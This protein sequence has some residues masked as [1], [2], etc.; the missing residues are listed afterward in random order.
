[1]IRPRRM[2]IP[3]RSA[4]CRRDVGVSVAANKVPGI[5]AAMCHDIYSAHQGVE[6]DNMNVVCLGARVIGPNLMLDLLRAVLTA[7]FTGEEH[8]VQRLG[9]IAALERRFCGGAGAYRVL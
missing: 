8:H 7:R 4:A 9:K 1:M 3:F 5:R 6:H 2:T